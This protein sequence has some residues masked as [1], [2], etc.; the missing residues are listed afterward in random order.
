LHPATDADGD[1]HSDRDGKTMRANHAAIDHHAVIDPIF[2]KYIIISIP[3]IDEAHSC[4][5]YGSREAA[6]MPKGLYTH[7]PPKVLELFSFQQTNKQT[8]KQT[9]LH[10]TLDGPVQ[11][12]GKK[13][14]W[15]LER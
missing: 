7:H 5:Q 1:Q 4:T 10:L 3:P 11:P 2:I 13:N 8:N 15:N 12:F 6:P 14:P 9:S